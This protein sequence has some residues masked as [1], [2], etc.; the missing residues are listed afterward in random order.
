MNIIASSDRVH[1]CVLLFDSDERS[2]D[3]AADVIWRWWTEGLVS[4]D[5]ADAMLARLDEMRG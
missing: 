2:Y 1:R 5:Q 4:D 3:K